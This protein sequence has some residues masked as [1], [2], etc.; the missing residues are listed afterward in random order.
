MRRAAAVAVVVALVVTGAARGDIGIRELTPRTAR[1]GDLVT[2]VAAGYLGP[3]PWQPM[4]VVMIPAK[5]AP[6][7]RPV[8]GGF[9]SPIARRSDLR[10]PRYRI[11]GAVSTWRPRDDTGVNARGVLRFRLP[12]VRPGRYVFALFC[13][14]CRPGPR[15]SLIIDR[16]LVLTVAA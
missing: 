10:P 11:V 15:G 14:P 5:L 9:G 6:K 4:P 8:P 1:A 2:V 12:P 7:P 3:R 16:R 13:E